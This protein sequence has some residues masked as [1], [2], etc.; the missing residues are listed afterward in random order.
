MMLIGYHPTGA[1]KLYDA[2]TQKVHICRDVIVNEAESWKWQVTP[3][4]KSE[5]QQGYVYLD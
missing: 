2:V 5:I 4:Y 1:Y 3:V